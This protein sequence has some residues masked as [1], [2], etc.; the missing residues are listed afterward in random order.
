MSRT[1]EDPAAIRP[2]ILAVDGGNSKADALLLDRSGT[3]LGAARQVAPSS[4]GGVNGSVDA[5][6][7]VIGAAARNAGFDPAARPIADVGVYCLAGADVPFDERRIDLALTERGWTGRNIV[8]NDTY[9]V[10]RAGTERGWG[11]G[12][13]CGAGMNC[14][15]IGPTGRH[16][17]FA[18]LGPLSG[19]IAA[20]GEWVGLAA[21]GAAMRAR[22]GRGPRTQLERAVPQ[23]FGLAR[24]ETVARAIHGEALDEAR[25]VELPPIVF[26]V[27]RTGDAVARGILDRLADE[28]VAMVTAT[29]R[30]LHVSRDE[31]D[32][33]LGGG[34]FLAEDRP[35]LARVEDGIRTVAP[36]ANTVRLR[37]PPVVG[38]ALIGLDEIGAAGRA[39]ERLRESVSHASIVRRSG[40]SDRRSTRAGSSSAGV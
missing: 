8:R 25:L 38:A 39:A 24:P 28:V 10:L 19:D 4:V 18:S 32:V 5:L 12:M 26:E 40:R 36:R 7:H 27:A 2:A 35:F 29:I 14:L 21:I 23:Y 13:V 16:V 31:V 17:R 15:G 1:K 11:V 22:D 30:R 33:V 3:L 20:G 34:I 9:A 6:R 37:L